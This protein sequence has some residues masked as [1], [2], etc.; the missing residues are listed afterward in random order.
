M[1]FKFP[2]KVMIGDAVFEV[3]YDKTKGGAEFCLGWE[4]EK[5]NIIIG[6][7]HYKSDEGDFLN[8]IIHELTEIIHVTLNTRYRSPD[9]D[10]NYHFC[11][12][13]KEHT[14]ACTMLAGLL[15]EF[16]K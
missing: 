7:K 2:K 9:N 11:Y 15:R 12:H 14:T 13:H 3:K 8:K 4:D 16:I 1:K 5:P 6:M 10:T